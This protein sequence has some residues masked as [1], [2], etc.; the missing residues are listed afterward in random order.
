MP[1]FSAGGQRWIAYRKVY[2][3]THGVSLLG[4][5]YMCHSCDNGA[6]PVGCCNPKHVRVGTPQ[7]NVDDAK[8]RNRF[9]LS[10][11]VVRNIRNLLARGHTQQNIADM[12]GCSRETVSA[13]ATKRTYGYITDPDEEEQLVDIQHQQ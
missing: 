1:Y 2:E 9:G 6:H 10:K 13:I 11:S 8:S 7:D 5:Q 3:L 12:Y 4:S